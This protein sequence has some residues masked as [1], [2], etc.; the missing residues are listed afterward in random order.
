MNVLFITLGLL[1][2]VEEKSLYPDLLRCFRDDGHQ[3]Y[4]VTASEKRTGNPTTCQDDHG[5]RVLRVKTGNVTKTA[6]LVEKGVS[7]LGLEGAFLRAIERHFAGVRFDLVLYSTPPIFLSR[8]VTHIK[9]RDGA[10]SFLLLK[11]IF[12]QNAV[13]LGMLSTRGPKG[14]IYS[15]FRRREQG[16]YAASD[17]IGCMSPANKAYLLA[18]NPTLAPQAVTVCPNAV[19]VID[20][21]LSAAQRQALRA[22]YDI[23]QDKT[24]FVMGG[25]LGEPQGVPFLLQCL[26]AVTD[27]RAFFLLI[28]SGTYYQTVSHYIQTQHPAHVRLMPRLPKREYD[29]LVGAC[30]VGM[31]FLDY[32]FTIPNF[33]C[34]LL[35]YMQARLP[36]L[37]VTDPCTDVGAAI[38]AGGFGWWCPS[39]D[40]GRFC[41]TVEQILQTNLAPL[42]QQAFDCLLQNYHVNGVYQT[43][44]GALG[45]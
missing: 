14:V 26:R 21:S 29:A 16:L 9:R 25:N 8:I 42:R 13:D 37:A 11:D 36:V 5:V 12:P 15:Y 24:V 44:C 1:E 18:H 31:I 45:G 23:P 34:R 19:E 35:A 28:G 17:H 33:P 7:L 38:T 2:G 22:R 6:S 10:A 40:A 39:N 20:H 43:I 32:R 30:D 3:V 4:A 27:P 41:A